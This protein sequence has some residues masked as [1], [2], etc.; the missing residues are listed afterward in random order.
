MPQRI[1]QYGASRAQT[2]GYQLLNNAA[3]LY[4][5][6]GY[7]TGSANSFL[8]LH[9]SLAA[10]ATNAIPIK[11][12]LVVSSNGYSYTFLKEDMASFLN[13]VYIALSTNETKYV[14]DASGTKVSGDIT[15]EDITNLNADTATAA[16]DLS[17]TTAGILNIWPANNEHHNLVAVRLGV[18]GAPASTRTWLVIG[19]QNTDDGFGTFN[20]TIF[21][22]LYT[23]AN[24]VVTNLANKLFYFGS[25][26]INL[27]AN[28]IV[29]GG[30][31]P[32][33]GCGVYVT[34][35]A[36]PARGG[37]TF[38]SPRTGDATIV[39]AYYL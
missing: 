35:D 8:Q 34:S 24:G 2:A 28:I 18:N 31:S 37:L 9:D 5:I 29:G 16:T 4:R 36:N 19:C 7:C 10:P 17:G 25:S 11:S 21:I 27:D 39:T 14:A 1:V 12:L 33:Y 3:T 23:E 13:G 38:P 30:V 26:G 15:L 22:P 20:A 32:C 6:D